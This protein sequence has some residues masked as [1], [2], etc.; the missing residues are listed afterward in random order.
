MVNAFAFIPVRIDYSQSATYRLIGYTI[1][2]NGRPIAHFA[3][4]HTAVSTYGTVDELRQA[5]RRDW[6]ERVYS[7]AA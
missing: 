6:R 5:G 4:G 7:A 2:A 3:D 1:G